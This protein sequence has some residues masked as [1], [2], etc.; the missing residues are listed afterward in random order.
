MKFLAILHTPIEHPGLIRQWVHSKGWNL[1]EVIWPENGRSL[2]HKNYDGFFIMGGPMGVYETEACPWLLNELD[3]LS[4]LISS[5]KPV[6]GICLGSQLLAKALGAPVF[7]SGLREIGWFP[8]HLTAEGKE[9]L[10]MDKSETTVLH[11]HGDTFQLP[12]GCLPLGYSQPN[13]LQGFYKE[14]NIYAFQFHIEVDEILLKEFIEG[15]ASY[16][17]EGLQK[18][19]NTVQSPEQIASLGEIHVPLCRSLLFK[20]LN[21]WLIK[22]FS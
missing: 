9:L 4:Q 14:P 19:P 16:I 6:L 5:Q 3:F 11:W 18:F 7:P 13:F 15:D 21:G 10:H 1:D 12:P 17:S 2:S 20:F 22:P 8:I